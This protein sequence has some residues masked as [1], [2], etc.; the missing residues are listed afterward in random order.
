MWN[1]L[2]FFL[3]SGGN[4]VDFMKKNAWH[5]NFKLYYFVALFYKAQI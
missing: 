3:E 2:Q 4:T 5:V 1:N